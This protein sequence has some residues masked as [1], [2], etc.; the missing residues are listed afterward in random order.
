MIAREKALLEAADDYLNPEL[1][2]VVETK[3]KESNKKVKFLDLATGR[4]Q[5]KTYGSK[6]GIGDK[7][8]LETYFKQLS[9]EALQK[10]EVERIVS[11]KYDQKVIL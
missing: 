10:L 3:L 5:L 11:Y 4:L 2:S 9:A 7:T 6:F 1:V 8:R